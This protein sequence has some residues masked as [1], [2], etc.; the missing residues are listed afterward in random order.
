MTPRRTS[1]PSPWSLTGLVAG[2]L[3]LA[4]RVR[5]FHCSGLRRAGVGTSTDQTGRD[6][7][8]GGECV[9][10]PGLG[11]PDRVETEALGRFGTDPGLRAESQRFVGAFFGSFN[12][13]VSLVGFLLRFS[14]FVQP[15]EGPNQ[16]GHPEVTPYSPTVM[17]R[18]GQQ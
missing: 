13:N 6:P 10:A 18:P 9:R 3:A 17:P 4:L 8:Q 16:F 14:W 2:G 5:A 7:G 11:R 15:R 12:A 1:L